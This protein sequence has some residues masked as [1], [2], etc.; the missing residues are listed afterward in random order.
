MDNLYV[1]KIGG[2]IVDDEQKLSSFLQTFAQVKGKKILVHGGGKLATKLG[3]TLGI[4]QKLVDGR[5]ITDAETLKVVTMVYAGYIN[6]NIVAQLQANDCN[7]IG[8][9]GAD[10]NAIQAHKRINAAIDYGFVGD[11]DQVDTNFFKQLF[12]KVSTVVVAPITHDKK[13]QLLNTNA[14]TI[15]QEIAKALSSHFNVQLIYSFEKSGVLLDANNDTTVIPSI[16][17]SYYQQLKNEQKIFA[18]MIPKLDNAFTALNNGVK[19]VIIGKA[20]ELNELIT[21][22]KGTSLTN[23]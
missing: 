7:A 3:E 10:G 17:P 16:R 4:E 1:I 14:D 18:G 19:K 20:E 5:R 23:E 12:D 13:G 21:G 6:K 15:A 11:I 2:N 9:S 22:T 8:I